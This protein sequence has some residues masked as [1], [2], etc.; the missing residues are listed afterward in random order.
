MNQKAIKKLI[1]PL[2]SNM[3][4]KIILLMFIIVTSH[5]VEFTSKERTIIVE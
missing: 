5:G 1:R 3:I 2:A 4:K